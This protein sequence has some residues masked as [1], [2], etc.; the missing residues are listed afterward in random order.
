M[1]PII[2]ILISTFLLISCR[3]AII[4]PTGFGTTH[5]PWMD[6]SL[7]HP[8]NDAYRKLLVKYNKLGLPGISLLINDRYGTWIGSVGK[9]DIKKNIDFAPCQ[10]SKVASITKL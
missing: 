10:V 7:M 2:Y 4:P 5:I 6:S 3:K 8:R 9:A 1:K